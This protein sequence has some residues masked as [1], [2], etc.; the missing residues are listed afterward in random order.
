MKQ[1][2]I[3][4]DYFVVTS[5]RLTFS[6][7]YPFHYVQN[8]SQLLII[9]TVLSPLHCVTG[10]RHVRRDSFYFTL[11]H[12]VA[13]IV[14]PKHRPNWFISLESRINDVLPFSHSSSFQ[15]HAVRPTLSVLRTLSHSKYIA[16]THSN[17]LILG[18]IHTT[19]PHSNTCMAF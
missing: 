13:R 8:Y 1:I 3:D 4:F 16:H 9:L 12:S 15:A 10:Y 14:Y 6:S 2:R 7:W 18:L 17:A 11:L 5:S 19:Y